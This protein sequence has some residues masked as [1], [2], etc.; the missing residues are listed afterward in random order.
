MNHV[1]AAK[2]PLRFLI[3]SA[4]CSIFLLCNPPEQPDLFTYCASGLQIDIRADQKLNTFVGEAHSIKL[5]VYQLTDNAAFIERQKKTD[6][7]KQL[8]TPNKFDPTVVAYEQVIVYPNE[9]KL[10]TFDRINQAK[11]IAVVAGYYL[12][13]EGKTYPCALIQIPSVPKK[14]SFLRKTG[15]FIKLLSPS[16]IRYVPHLAIQLQLTS[17]TMYETS[18]FR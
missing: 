4:L 14:K 9:S 6:A 1:A 16:D 18:M 2:D 15:E 11:W 5:A 3:L 12:S 10:W 17:T 13:D 8:L 7:L